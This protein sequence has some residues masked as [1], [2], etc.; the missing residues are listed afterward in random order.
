MSAFMHL[1]IVDLPEPEAPTIRTFSPLF[2][3]KLMFLSVGP[4]CVL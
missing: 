4:A 1:A 3:E 2:M